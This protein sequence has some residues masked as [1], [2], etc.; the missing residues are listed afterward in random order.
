MEI[1]KRDR[2]TLERLEEELWREEMRFDRRRMM[3]VLSPDFFEFG[4]SGRTYTRDDS[5]SVPRQ[6]IQAVF[7]L[8]EFRARLLHPDVAQVTYNSVVTYD[9][10]V[11]HARRSSI[12]SRTPSGWVLRFHQGT[13]FAEPCAP[14]NG[15][16]AAS[17][18]NS[19][20]FSGPPSVS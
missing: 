20:A 17:V 7:P 5:L 3:E 6:P 15:G 9:G 4:R 18:D 12:W 13:P 1:S 19:H 16:P 8:S 2:D 11:Q 14:P 10:V